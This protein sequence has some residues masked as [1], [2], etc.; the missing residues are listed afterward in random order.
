[1]TIYTNEIFRL[2]QLDWKDVFDK[3]L[4]FFIPLNYYFYKFAI[5]S[6]TRKYDKFWLGTM[7]TFVWKGILYF[8]DKTTSLSQVFEGKFGGS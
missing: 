2:I 5:K 8:I 4:N 7:V 1:M 6:F 3:K